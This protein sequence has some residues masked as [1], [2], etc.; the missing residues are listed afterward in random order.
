VPVVAGSAELRYGRFVAWSASSAIAW[1]S[2]IVVLA[3]VLGDDAADLL[4]RAGLVV[5]IAV[6]A[7]IAVVLVVRRRRR[8]TS[9]PS[10]PSSTGG[11]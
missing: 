6:V 4:D 10:R 2:T 8:S 1:A 11:G 7:A 3:Y 5:S 9:T